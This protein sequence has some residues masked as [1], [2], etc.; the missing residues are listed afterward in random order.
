M[1]ITL[2]TFRQCMS[3]LSAIVAMDQSLMAFQ[4]KRLLDPLDLADRE[5]QVLRCF[6][7]RLFPTAQF[8]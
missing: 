5:V 1:S 2:Q 8:F 4:A 7:I 6:L 3:W